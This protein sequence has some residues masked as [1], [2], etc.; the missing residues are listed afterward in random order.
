[1]AEVWSVLE[2]V[3]NPKIPNKTNG[4]AEAPLFVTELCSD[5][6]HSSHAVRIKSMS[7]KNLPSWLGSPLK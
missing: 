5:C 4:G 2:V 7:G 6:R 3:L 1:M